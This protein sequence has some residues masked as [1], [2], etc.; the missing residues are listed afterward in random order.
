MVNLKRIEGVQELRA[1]FAKKIAEAIKDSNPSVIVGYTANYAIWVHENIKM[2]WKGLPRKN[3][4]KVSIGTLRE[5]DKV[6][7]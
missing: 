1:I 6:S 7:S 5:E 4:I 2:S 3:P